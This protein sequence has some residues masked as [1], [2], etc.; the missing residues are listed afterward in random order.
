MNVQSVILIA[1]RQ[2]SSVSCF[3]N[4]LHPAHGKL[5]G[6][7]RE[8]NGRCSTMKS[9]GFMR[10]GPH[11]PEGTGIV[12]WDPIDPSEIESGSP[13]QR[14]HI[15]H[16]IPA[17]GYMAGVWDCTANILK[18]GPYP[19]HEFMFLLEGSVTI[20]LEDGSETTV[21]AGEAFVIP[22]GLPCKWIQSGYVRKFFMIFEDPSVAPAA[23]VSAQGVILP[24]R[25]GPDGG[26]SPMENNDASVFVGAVPTQNN[27]TYF[28]DPS[29]Q[30]RVGVW[31]CGPCERLPARFDRNELMCVLEGSLTLTASNGETETFG[32]GDA[33]Y[34]T[35]GSEFAWANKDYIRKFYAIYE[36]QVS[37]S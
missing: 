34:V 15:Y 21:N 3:S 1:K 29:G 23:D 4:D 31:D 20:A 17:A 16:E 14:G 7:G 12:E 19:V 28:E 32:P 6:L 27:H 24:R 33:A 37:S 26:L 18:F 8:E 5:V 36:P 25:T 13:V 10:F 30:M 11:G 22:K 9:K 2:K 35:E